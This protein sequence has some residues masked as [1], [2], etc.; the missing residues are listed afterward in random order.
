[1][2][3]LDLVGLSEEEL[4]NTIVDL[5]EQLV[6]NSRKGG[7]S[8]SHFKQ[9]LEAKVEIRELQSEIVDLQYE[10]T[11]ISEKNLMEDINMTD[12]DDC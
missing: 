12:D 5:Q 8:G 1:M 2:S 11:R 9:L 7:W 6:R 4:Q 10:L 3:I